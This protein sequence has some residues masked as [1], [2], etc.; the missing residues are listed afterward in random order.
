VSTGVLIIFLIAAA[1]IA[2]FILRGF[3]RRR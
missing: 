3:N 2:F 1:M